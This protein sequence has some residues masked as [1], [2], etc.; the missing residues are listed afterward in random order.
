VT[1]NEVS[2]SRRQ[3]LNRWAPGLATLLS[4]RRAWFAHDVLAGLALSAILLPV[5][6]GYA[7]AAGVP[8]IHGLYATIVPL[9]VYAIFGP[10][11]IMVL[12]PDSTMAAVIAALIL[13]LSGGSATHAIA[14]AGML[15][16][17]SGAFALLIGFARLGLVADLLSKPIRIGFL[18]AIAITVI[19]GQ[20]PKVLGFSTVT[21][22]LPATTWHIVQGIADGQ[23]NVVACML[24]VG[25]LALV[26]VL[27][28][29]RP[30]WPGILLAVALATFASSLL[31]L[32]ASANIALLGTLPQGLPS[33]DIP[34]VTFNEILQLI[35]G[36]AIIAL[37]S[38]ADTSVLSRALAQR[39]GIDVNQNQEMIA[40]GAANIAT[41][42]FQGFSVSS[43]TSRTPVAEAAGA[44]TQVAG[45]VG[46]SAI[47]MLLLLAPNLME[48]LPSATL[49]AIVIAACLSFAD[50]KSM[51]QLY[52]LRKAEFS[53]SVASFL[54]VAFVGVIEGIFIAIVLSLMVLVWNTWHP[55]SAILVR[56][57]GSKGYHDNR[58]HPE[59]RSI[60]GLVLF[61]W[62]AP[63][64]FA[65]AE[66]FKQ[67]VLQAVNSSTEP[68][69]RVVVA[70]DAITDV[71]ITAAEVLVTLH[72]EL[73]AQGIALRF[74]GLK[75]P[76]KDHLQR[77]GTLDV[78]GSAIF[79]PTVGSAANQYRADHAV[80]WK[81]W[82]EV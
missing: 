22:S 82:D 12:G 20:L 33:F 30:R 78:I 77:Y 60:P 72:S 3:W 71:D 55:Y 1:T 43:S 67:Q 47:A 37:L 40:I 56:V 36:A 19:I 28:H 48:N 5:G 75:G 21:D 11:R 10:S 2:P 6:M 9:L 25:C 15:A 50:F 8:A 51:A 53:L 23:A 76:A 35:P 39:S 17:L 57:D 63:L 32:G 65:N 70:A 62:D 44:I 34:H 4:Y 24:G 69:L 49:G 58:R 64:F 61:R 29:Y 14:L 79:S 81:D 27:K 80:E 74:A 13:P 45:L 31:N 59:G 73:N 46:A 52:R 26:L 66:L 42:L 54:G 41:G 16:L 68:V 38:F 7:E 18:N